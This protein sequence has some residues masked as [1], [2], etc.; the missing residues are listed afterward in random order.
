MRVKDLDRETTI[1]E[2]ETFKKRIE[3]NNVLKMA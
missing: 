2:I 1:K 3:F